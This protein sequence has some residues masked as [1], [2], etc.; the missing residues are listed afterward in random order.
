MACS[1]EGSLALAR[2]I[3][4]GAAAA[5]ADAIQF[6]IWNLA[7]MVVP[8]HPDYG[9]LQRLELSPADWAALHWY[10]RTMHPG[11]HVVAC[12][13]ETGSVDFCETL[14]VDAY[15]I[16]SS[17]LSNPE[18]LRHVAATGRRIDLSVGA[19]TIDEIVNAI[20]AIKS[21]GES[22]IW[23]M[24]GLQSFPTPPA[25][26]RLAFMT[27]LARLFELPVGYQDHS[28]A[29]MPA[30]F[31]LPAAAVGMGVQI[32]E[33]HVTIDR[34]KRGPDY[35]AALHP[36]EL[37][38]F[39]AMVREIEAATGSG[40]PMAF[41]EAEERYRAY[42]KKSIVAARNLAEGV[43]VAASDILFMRATELGLPPDQSQRLLGRKTRRAVSAFEI[44]LE[45]DLC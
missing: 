12:V 20:A 4:D 24:Y 7:D 30:A 23:L 31:F 1:H 42:S 39:V 22:R 34:S 5:G 33:K 32:L 19:S 27:K 16:H 18:L 10:V 3:I 8:R 38:R 21:V 14:P 11:M 9:M 44:L 41:S 25:D 40:M 2:S 45:R 37:A 28:D 43:T 36:D 15:K 35:Q 6:Q 26:A 13:C 17:D 29:E